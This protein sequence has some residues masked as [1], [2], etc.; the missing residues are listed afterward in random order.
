MRKDQRKIPEH[1]TFESCNKQLH[2]NLITDRYTKIKRPVYIDYCREHWLLNRK[3]KTKATVKVKIRVCKIPGCGESDPEKM[4]KSN[5]GIPLCKIHDTERRKKFVKKFV[6]NEDYIEKQRLQWKLKMESMTDEEK[7]EYFKPQSSASKE[8]H[9][10]NVIKDPGYYK[11]SV[12]RWLKRLNSM[13]QEARNL[14]FTKVN[15]K[16]IPM[17]EEQK[18]AWKIKLSNSLI[19]KPENEK[20]EAQLK[21][22]ET[23]QKKT[24]EEIREWYKKISRGVNK[25]QDEHPERLIQMRN[26]F[27]TFWARM[28]N[29]NLT[30]SSKAEFLCYSFLKDY[31]PDVIHHW[32]LDEY[33]FDFYIP[34]LNLLVCFE[35]VYFHGYLLLQSEHPLQKFFKYRSQEKGKQIIL[36][37][38]RDRRK[39][40][41]YKNMIRIT[42][43]EFK[44][45]PNLILERIADYRKVNNLK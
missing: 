5:V 26:Q 4:A 43:I 30:P 36:T 44:K 29:G 21:R 33:I 23:L 24:A 27:K 12:D 19:N 11:R 6:H 17:T 35:G 20:I 1:C 28:K 45:N 9:K 42:D 22:K 14:H 13:T 15:A 25:F 18:L 40:K 2:F 34:G 38:K 16:R 37:M 31:Y 39:I 7:F 41:K 3:L 32:E 8:W 10:Q